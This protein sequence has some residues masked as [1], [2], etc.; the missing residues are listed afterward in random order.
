MFRAKPFEKS[1]TRRAPILGNLLASS[2]V[3]SKGNVKTWLHNDG[4]YK[5]S[6]NRCVTCERIL[7]STEFVSDKTRKPFKIRN[8]INCN[9]KCVVRLRNCSKC[10]IQYVS[11]TSRR[12]KDR[13]REH[14]NQI[15]SGSNTTVVSRHF[16]ECG[17]GD[18]TYLKIQGIEKLELT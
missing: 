12:L 1:V 11:C 8:F 14:I 16:L 2:V 5:C 13:M 18:I 7:V 15:V 6:M 9:S 4:T 10:G 17:G 3:Q